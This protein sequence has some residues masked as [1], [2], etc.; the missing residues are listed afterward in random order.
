MTTHCALCGGGSVAPDGH[1]WDRGHAQPAFHSHLEITTGGGAGVSD[2][3]LRRGVNADAMALAGDGAWTIGVVCD[4][5]SM[6]PRSERAARIAADTGAL[7]DAR[8]LVGRALDAG[9][10]DNITA[11]LLAVTAETGAQI[12]GRPARG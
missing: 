10:H 11:V 2:R 6:S 8:A 4:G 7:A 5:G 3:G 1:C 9:G 12:G